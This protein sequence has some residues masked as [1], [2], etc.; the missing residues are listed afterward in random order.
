MVGMAGGMFKMGEMTE[1]QGGVLVVAYGLDAFA[2]AFPAKR[3]LFLLLLFHNILRLSLTSDIPQ[4]RYA[5]L[6]KYR[7][8]KPSLIHETQIAL[9]SRFVIEK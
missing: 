6:I 8:L 1:V 4:C 7:I 9:D 3:L 5:C 2:R